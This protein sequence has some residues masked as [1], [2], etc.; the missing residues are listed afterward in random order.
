MRI[1]SI[2][3]LGMVGVSLAAC[4]TPTNQQIGTLTGAT[5]GGV[6]GNQFGSGSGKAAATIVGTLI[7]GYIGSTIGQSLDVQQQQRAA[8]AQAQA[9]DYGRPGAPVAWS[10]GN[11]RGQVTPGPSYQ[12]NNTQCRDYTHQ[13][14]ID[15]QPETARGTAC[16][17]PDGTWRTVS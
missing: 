3:V 12:V 6:I 7:G 17:N 15:G 10:Q 13:I 5:V 2:I 16:R 4:Q 8:A 9:L 1:G 11:A 14:W